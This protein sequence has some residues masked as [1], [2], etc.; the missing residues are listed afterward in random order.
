MKGIC[1]A[2]RKD[3][4]FDAHYHTVVEYVLAKVMPATPEWTHI[5]KPE[6][7]ALAAD[8]GV[9]H[10][11]W[12][13]TRAPHLPPVTAAKNAARARSMRVLSDFKRV[14]LS[15]PPVTEADLRAMG[16]YPDDDTP[17]TINPL[18]EFPLVE[19]RTAKAR[20][21]DFWFKGRENK[22]WGKPKRVHG[23]ELKW[24]I[25]DAPPASVDD[26]PHSE[27]ATRSPLRLV[28]GEADRGKRLYYIARWETN[29]AKKSEFSEIYWVIIP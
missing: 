23:M 7:E 5:P 8:Y 15:R 21:V 22:R 10:A 20:I 25:A 28:F 14:Y 17:T 1:A 26:F 16:I 24:V 9:W 27:F 3:V 19:T 29:A 11:A 6:A 4:D 18:D 12:E 2:P 13:A